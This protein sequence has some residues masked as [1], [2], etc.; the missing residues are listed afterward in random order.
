MPLILVRRKLSLATLSNCWKVLRTFDT[1]VVWIQ[2]TGLDKN[3]GKVII[4]RIA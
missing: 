4:Q 3:K 2:T 1:K